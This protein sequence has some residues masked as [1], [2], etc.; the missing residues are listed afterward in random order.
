[1]INEYITIA[2]T[3]SSS[4]TTDINTLGA[5]YGTPLNAIPWGQTNIGLGPNSIETRTSN[6]EIYVM[7]KYGILQIY[8]PDKTL[9]R[10]VSVFS[11]ASTNFQLRFNSSES[12]YGVIRQF[13]LRIVDTATDA[14]TLTL[15]L[16]SSYTFE[17]DPNNTNFYVGFGA[18]TVQ[19]Y[20]SAGATVGAAFNVTNVSRPRVMKFQPG[21]NLIWVGGDTGNER[22]NRLSYF[23]ATTKVVTDV[24]VNTVGATV[25]R[26]IGTITGMMFYGTRIFLAH[27]SCRNA[28]AAASS[29]M[30]TEIDNTGTILNQW[31]I[32]GTNADYADGCFYG[33]YTEPV[34]LYPR[35]QNQIID[36]VCTLIL[37]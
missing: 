20:D 35:I 9:N 18:A 26:Q 28:S 32:F 8:N 30:I 34:L 25:G 19:E 36:F 2:P 16:T 1:M 6:N 15:P 37:P 27:T 29:K 5:E 11:T 7:D 24:V 14:L 10:T 33:N 31:P 22:A 21:T 23:D 13:D 3:G 4:G 17:F 12:L